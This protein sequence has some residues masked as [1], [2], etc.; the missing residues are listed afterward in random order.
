MAEG[1]GQREKVQVA[2]RGESRVKPQDGR[3][4]RTKGKSSSGCEG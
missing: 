3:R 4:E 2:V 1:K